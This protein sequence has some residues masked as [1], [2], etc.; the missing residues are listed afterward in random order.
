MGLSDKQIE[1]SAENFVKIV[2]NGTGAATK[3]IATGTKVATDSISSGTKSVKRLIGKNEKPLEVPDGL[4]QGAHTVKEVT[5]ATASLST[6][7]LLA[8]ID[9]TKQIGKG[10]VDG[11]TQNP[12]G[13]KYLAIKTEK[14]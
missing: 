3:A 1:A 11:V 2:E 5:A 13:K 8:S 12:Y 10:V 9:I 14:K 7:V 6:A 4:K